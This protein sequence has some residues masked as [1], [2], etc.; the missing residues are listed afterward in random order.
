MQPLNVYYDEKI[1]SATTMTISFQTELWLQV[2]YILY[3][4]HMEILS[5]LRLH[6]HRH[7]WN[8]VGI[9]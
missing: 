5:G 8:T 4:L 2:F 1:I 7:K 9:L 3:I 6:K